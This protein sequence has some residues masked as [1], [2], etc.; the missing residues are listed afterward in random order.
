[1]TFDDRTDSSATDPAATAD[2][3]TPA[4]ATILVCSS[5]RGADGADDRPRPGHLLAEAARA[6]NEDAGIRIVEIECLGNCKRRLSAAL[7]CEGA[8]SYVFGDLAVENGADLV[9]GAKLFQTSE[10]GLMPWR[11]RPE[12]LKRGLV[13]RLPPATAIALA[14]TQKDPS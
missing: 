13:S 10:N 12:C 4:A 5:C 9:A 3:P 2:A 14:A 11:G 8:W 7:L 6:A 1:M